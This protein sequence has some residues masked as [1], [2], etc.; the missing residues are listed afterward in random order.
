MHNVAWNACSGVTTISRALFLALVMKVIPRACGKNAGDGAAWHAG[1]AYIYQGEEI[2]MT[3]PHFTR[4]TD[5][6]TWRASICLPSC[7]TM[8]VMRRVIGNPRQ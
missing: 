4:I 5:I 7:A 6:A 8:V 3:N 1:N 2:G